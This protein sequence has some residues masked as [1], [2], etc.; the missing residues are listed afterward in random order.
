MSLAVTGTIEKEAMVNPLM[1]FHEAGKFGVALGPVTY[2]PQVYITTSYSSTGGLVTF[3]AQPPSIATAMD[4]Q[5]T[6]KWFFQVDVTAVRGSSGFVIDPGSYDAPRAFPAA[7]CMTS[8]SANINNTKVSLQLNSVLHALLQCNTDNHDLSMRLSTAPSA[9]DEYQNYSDPVDVLFPAVGGQPNQLRGSVSD[10]LQAFGESVGKYS[11]NRGGWPLGATVTGNPHGAPG[12][13]GTA[14]VLFESTEPMFLSPFGA[15]TDSYSLVGVS[16]FTVQCQFG[17]L[18]HA[19]SHSDHLAASKFGPGFPGTSFAISLWKNPELHVNFLT[20]SP[21]ISIPE[22]VVYPYTD[23]VPYQTDIG[24]PLAPGAQATNTSANIQLQAVPSRILVYVSQNPKDVQTDVTTQTNSTDTFARIDQIIVNFD[25]VTGIL[26]AASTDDLFNECVRNGLMMNY[27]QWTQTRGSV[28]I[29]DVAKNLALQNPADAPGLTAQKQLQV[30]VKYTNINRT[31]SLNFT[32]W[33]VTMVPGVLTIVNGTSV[34]QVGVL[35]QNDI[36]NAIESPRR[37]V[38][39]IADNFYGGK[40]ASAFRF[41]EQGHK[42]A[43]K[44]KPLSRALS[45]A[46]SAGYTPNPLLGDVANA[47][48]YGLM[49]D[50]GSG[51]IGGGMRG[52]RAISRKTLAKRARQ[53]RMDEVDD[54]EDS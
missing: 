24:G 42:L 9:L 2:T 29:L 18:A 31:K 34:Q 30:T 16:Q 21:A 40:L 6:L 27:Q 46:R 43:Q 20:V 53:S 10:P 44:F 26:S 37:S 11:P 54:D 8:I 36:L 49:D 25:N 12:T 38:M 50:G 7:S 45:V 5:V 47:T 32:I 23:V 3:V 4:R 39:Q 48:G 35:T 28:M 41:L 22:A 19:W 17:P 33:I 52:G 51:L 14:Q 15:A 13:T 1:R